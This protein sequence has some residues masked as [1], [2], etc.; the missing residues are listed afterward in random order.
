MGQYDWYD[1]W[2]WFSTVVKSHDYAHP[3]Q[4]VFQL[5]ADIKDEQFKKIIDTCV[6]KSDRQHI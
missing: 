1:P 5:F 3:V 2:H 6:T 4:V